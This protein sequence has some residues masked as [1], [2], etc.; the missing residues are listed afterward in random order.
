MK[1]AVGYRFDTFAF[2][3][4][5]PRTIESFRIKDIIKINAGLRRKKN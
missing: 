1:C 4:E 5:I 2:Y 3:N